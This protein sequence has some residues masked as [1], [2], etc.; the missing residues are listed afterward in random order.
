[1][2]RT[3]ADWMV[4]S[5]MPENR[6]L[7]EMDRILP[8]DWIEDTLRRELHNPGGGRPPYPFMVMF[9]MMLIQ[10]W[11]G[12][13]DAQSE[14]QCA[15]RMT[16]R[17][18]LG[19]GLMDKIPDSSTLEDFRH[20]LEAHQLQEKLLSRM[21]AL[22]ACKG[23][24]CSTGTLV[25]ATFVKAARP[26]ADPDRRHGHKGNGYSASVSVSKKRKLVRKV[27]TTDASVHDSQSL[28][29]AL[30]ENPGKVYAD[31]GY[32]GKPCEKIIVDAGG[33]PCIPYKKPKGG[34]LEPWQKGVNTILSKTRN[35]VEHIFARWKAT[36][37]LVNCRYSGRLKV[38]GFHCGMA[39]AYNF[40]RLGFLL[41]RK[42]GFSWA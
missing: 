4:E 17:K 31:L 5:G 36:F 23:L 2:G 7:E 11:Y 28:E 12:L 30:P 41:R 37:R 24:V 26:K 35:G 20:K 29:E 34:E 18:F 10:W 38:H 8:W 33:T 6:F 3:L 16:F 15:D 39:L 32:W 14:F 40:H 13:S 27:V 21:D 42:P 22:L 19:L 1:M 9:R 25:D